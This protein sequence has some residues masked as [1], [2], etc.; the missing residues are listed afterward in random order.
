MAL[1]MDKEKDTFLPFR[2][3]HSQPFYHSCLLEFCI[4]P[5]TIQTNTDKCPN[6]R[7]GKGAMNSDHKARK[8]NSIDQP[9]KENL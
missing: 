4:I 6:R 1:E 7:E 8:T 5:L 3:Y 9:I 2:F